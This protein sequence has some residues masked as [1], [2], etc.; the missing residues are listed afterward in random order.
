MFEG[1]ILNH[2][3]PFVP[4]AFCNR[5]CRPWAITFS[6]SA[7]VTFAITAMVPASSLSGVVQGAAI[8]LQLV[9]LSKLWPLLKS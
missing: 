7:L 5:E 1:S 2:K 8:I 9:A 3:Q 6:V 4:V